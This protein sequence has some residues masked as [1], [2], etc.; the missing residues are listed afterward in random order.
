MLPCCGTEKHAW[1]RFEVE[2]DWVPP[3]LRCLIVGENPGDLASEYFYERPDTYKSD[4]V[5][6]RKALLRGPRE[7]GLIARPGSRIRGVHDLA[8]PGV[9]FIHRASR[10]GEASSVAEAV[11][12][13]VTPDPLPEP[14]PEDG[15]PFPK[16]PP[17]L[18]ATGLTETMMATIPTKLTMA[19][20]KVNMVVVNSLRMASVSLSTLAISLPTGCRSKKAMSRSRT[21][22]KSLSFRTETRRT[23]K[24]SS[25]TAIR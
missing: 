22:P 16:E 10:E 23:P 20:S 9:R 7:Q 12:E 5:E 2:R 6:V 1:D 14:E 8:R 3:T 17:T 25:T 21:C 13:A 18:A 11:A 4:E 24:P 15:R 19:P